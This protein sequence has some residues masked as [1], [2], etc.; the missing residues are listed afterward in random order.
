[1]TDLVY[2]RCY[3]CIYWI[4]NNK[5]KEKEG[6]CWDTT[7]SDSC[8]KFERMPAVLFGSGRRVQE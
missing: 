3:D 2:H 4:C 7:A 8:E 5:D 6:L 1:M